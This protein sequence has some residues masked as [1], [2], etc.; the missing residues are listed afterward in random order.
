M[1]WKLSPALL[2]RKV[3]TVD[4]N[5][6][7]LQRLVDAW[8]PFNPDVRIIL[9]VSPI[10]LLATFRSDECNVVVANCHSKSVL[11]VAAEEFAARN[12][13]VTYFPA[14]EAVLYG[15]RQP[16]REDGRHVSRQ[17]LDRVM[18]MF[19]ETFCADHGS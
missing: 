14:Y 5:I 4:D 1:P 9:T 3:L 7:E 16:F 18:T 12:D 2:G 17:A 15:T 8:R 11:R 13:G 6:R 10:P 19:R